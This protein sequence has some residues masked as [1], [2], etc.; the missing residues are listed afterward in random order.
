[1]ADDLRHVLTVRQREIL[2][3]VVQEYVATGQ[4]VGS[5]ALVERAGLPVSPST[6]RGDLA[7]LEGRGL[8]MHPHTSAGRVPTERGYRFYADEVLRRQDARPGSFPLDFSALR[9]EVDAALQATTEMLSSVT[10]LLAMI[11]APSFE[12]NTVR[13]VE[14]L[15][16]QTQTVMVVVITTTG[17]VSKR[18]FTFDAP[19]DPGLVSWAGEYLNDRLRG[20]RLG[21]TQ[22]RRRLDESTLGV[23]ERD[24]LDVVRPAF[25]ELVGADQRLFVAGT[26]G[27]LGDLSDDE[28]GLYRR[29]LT[30]LE[31]RAALLEILGQA[32]DP[33]RAFVRLG[34]DLDHPAFRD[35]ALVGAS[36]GLTN[37]P[38]GAVSL[39]GPVRMDY[40]KAVRSVRSAAIELSRFVEEVYE[41]N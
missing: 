2:A 28:L 36:Y 22:L 26:A 23:A 4:P 20:V 32:L 15:L 7:E 38:L 29:V 30:T 14:V 17:D 33:S 18:A 5:K 11:S 25:T 24:F 39:L 9:R 37:R 16:L 40:E 34:G 13:H 12:A 10:R 27:L 35:V 1:M 3:R 41:D 31:K 8:L 19:V 6:V 21:T